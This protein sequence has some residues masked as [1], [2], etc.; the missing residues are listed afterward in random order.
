M[1]WY[2]GM[3]GSNSHG[4]TIYVSF[5]VKC[6]CY[7]RLWIYWFRD[8]GATIPNSTVTI[9]R[10]SLAGVGHSRPDPIMPLMLCSVFFHAMAGALAL[11]YMSLEIAST[12]LRRGKISGKP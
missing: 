6:V 12:L 10:T 11:Y 4:L 9:G 7:T 8:Y 3:S 2:T 5:M 1:T